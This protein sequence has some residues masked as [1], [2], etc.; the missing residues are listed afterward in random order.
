MA[1]F[2]PAT[3]ALEEMLK[4]SFGASMKDGKGTTSVE[5]QGTGPYAFDKLFHTVV[6]PEEES[7]DFPVIEWCD[8]DDNVVKSEDS[9]RRSL[10][11]SQNANIIAARSSVADDCRRNIPCLM[12]C[13]SFLADLAILGSLG[14]ESLPYSSSKAARIPTSH[15]AFGID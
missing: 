12:R 4:R 13:R 9:Q 6:V 3:R 10:S 14:V 8:D 2:K 11:Q 5:H 15:V 1:E 7:F